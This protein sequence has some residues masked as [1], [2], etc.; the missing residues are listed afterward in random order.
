MSIAE[1]QE[2]SVKSRKKL[3]ETTRGI[4]FVAHISDIYLQVLDIGLQ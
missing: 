1:K 4:Y 3:A 2:Q